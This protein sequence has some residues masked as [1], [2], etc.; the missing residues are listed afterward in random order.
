MT[1]KDCKWDYLAA[2][3]KGGQGANKRATGV[4][5]THAASGAVGKSRDERS[6]LQNKRTA[7][8]RMADD[9]KFKSWHRMEVAKV[10]GTWRDIE[11]VVD[12]Q[13]KQIKIEVMQNDKW[14]EE[15]DV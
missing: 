8:M 9:P 15:S 14:I 5:C 10:L 1:A 3:T 11:K 4:R 6:Q 12:E 7:F 13:M 2:S